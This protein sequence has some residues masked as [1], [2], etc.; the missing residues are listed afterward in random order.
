MSIL[1]ESE[2]TE[3]NMQHNAHRIDP[4]RL[5]AYAELLALDFSS[6][7]PSREEINRLTTGWDEGATY[8]Q[9]VLEIENPK[10]WADFMQAFDTKRDE[11]VLLRNRLF[12][13]GRQNPTV[14]EELYRARHNLLVQ[15]IDND[16]ANLIKD[17]FCFE[18][19]SVEQLALLHFLRHH[20]EQNPKP[21][22]RVNIGW[23]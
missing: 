2:I 19:D 14:P 21:D 7:L 11:W 8:L 16:K 13:L 15:T 18:Q 17:T 23:D 20:E 22:T 12:P 5:K 10:R 4:M 1:N 9:N 3:N 6:G